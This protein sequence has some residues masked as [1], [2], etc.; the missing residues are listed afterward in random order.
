MPNTLINRIGHNMYQAEENVLCILWLK[1]HN[2][3]LNSKWYK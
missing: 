3:E 2:D 1:M